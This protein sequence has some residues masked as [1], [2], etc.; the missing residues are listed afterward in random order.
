[1]AT[2]AFASV[3]Q[4]LDENYSK[5]DPEEV[6]TRI[7]KVVHAPTT[8]CVTFQSVL[9]WIFNMSKELFL[10]YLGRGDVEQMKMHYNRLQTLRPKKQQ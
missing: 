3:V 10:N 2:L 6:E 7:S 5:R 9:S 4:G 8:R 1:M